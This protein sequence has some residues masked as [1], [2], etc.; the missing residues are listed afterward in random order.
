MN[1]PLT[2]LIAAACLAVSSAS[3][4]ERFTTDKP[5]PL[6]LA[7]PAESPLVRFD[8]Q[9]QLSGKFLVLWELKN[10]RPRYLRVTFFPDVNSSARLPR[11]AGSEPVKE[12]L[13]SS[14]EQAAPRLIEL[15]SRQEN[16][17][18]EQVSS[19]GVA[20]IVVRDYR[21]V[22]ECDQR[23]YL[24]KLVSAK[25]NPDTVASARTARAGC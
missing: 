6:K 2:T 22:T 19:E 5:S 12:L 14:P 3:A 20:T 15:A 10:D 24:A 4:A 1:H 11:P 25:K 9:A 23:W 21:I 16:L 7:K 17:P 13:L 18:R 8:G